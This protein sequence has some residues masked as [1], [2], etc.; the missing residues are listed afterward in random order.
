MRTEVVLVSM[1]IVSGCTQHA[2]ISSRRTRT[3]PPILS[4]SWNPGRGY[5]VTFYE[6]GS[7]LFATGM[8][9]GGLHLTSDEREDLSQLVERISLATTLAAYEDPF[10]GSSTPGRGVR[11]SQRQS[12][13]YIPFTQ[14]QSLP[15]P[16]L[17][18]MEFV[19]RVHVAHHRELFFI[20][21]AGG[22]RGVKPNYAIKLSVRTVTHLAF[23]RCAPV[24][25]AAYRVRYT[26]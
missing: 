14:L 5:S 26:D 6:D 7:A 12:H 2:H 1:L 3:I 24:R 20:P 11:I 25:P 8:D 17:D 4:L 9:I 16:V 21:E 23:A 19:D 13:W 22:G 18:L 10:P 15:R